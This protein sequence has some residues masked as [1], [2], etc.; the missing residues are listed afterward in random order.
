M[1]NSIF[2]L[3]S[4]DKSPSNSSDVPLLGTPLTTKLTDK[5]KEILL[6][7]ACG[8]NL[9]QIGKILFIAPTTVQTHMKQVRGKLGATNK[10]QAL[11]V[12]LIEGIVTIEEIKVTM[13]KI[14]G[15]GG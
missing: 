8:L 13:Q 15:E 3:D 12:A 14:K 10:I 9:V 7:V 2:P 6:L 1:K 11:S 4:L 5:Q